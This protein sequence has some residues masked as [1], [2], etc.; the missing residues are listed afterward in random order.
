M[1]GDLGSA[2]QLVA[3]VEELERAVADEASLVEWVPPERQ[4]NG[5]VQ[6]GWFHYSDTAFG[7]LGK[8]AR[9]LDS[10]GIDSDRVRDL[11]RSAADVRTTALPDVAA[12]LVTI[13]HGERIADGLVASC[14][15]NGS[16]VAA[17]TRLKEAVLPLVRS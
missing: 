9:L 17:A 16:L 11:P 7:V 12:F 13:M 1:P 15:E 5:V 6:V 14:L 3:A 2:A 10:A 4:A 8:A